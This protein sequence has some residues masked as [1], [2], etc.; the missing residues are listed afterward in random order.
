MSE[1]GPAPGL[2]IASQQDRRREVLGKITA[3]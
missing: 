2:F 3:F 1:A